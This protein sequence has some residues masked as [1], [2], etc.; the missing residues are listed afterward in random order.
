MW[1]C[2]KNLMISFGK[3][4]SSTCFRKR[5]GLN[6]QVSSIKNQELRNMEASSR[7][8]MKMASTKLVE[9]MSEA[10]LGGQVKTGFNNQQCPL[11]P[12]KLLTKSSIY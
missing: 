11:H 3:S 8:R 5:L 9:C 12:W 6:F 1:N 4:Q 10:I 7:Q 2:S